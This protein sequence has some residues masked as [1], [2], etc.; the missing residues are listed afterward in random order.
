MD[1]R[2]FHV[3]IMTT[4]RNTVLYVGMTSDLIA[5]VHQHRT[6]AVPGF[7]HRYNVVKLAYYESHGDAYTAIQREKQLKAEPRS[8][9]V[10][11]IA[12]MNPEWRDLW[13]DIAG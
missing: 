12:S 4:A 2:D 9:K 3:Y 5:R 13:E 10:A 8:R 7:T 6:H 1:D 11:L